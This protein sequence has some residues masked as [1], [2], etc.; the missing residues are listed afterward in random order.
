MNLEGVICCL[1]DSVSSS[2]IGY[3][4]CRNDYEDHRGK[5]G[6]QEKKMLLV[7]VQLFATSWT[8]T[9]QA[10]LS[11]TISQSLLKLV[12]IQSVIPSNHL[13]L[14][15][16]LLLL[17]STFPRIRVFSNESALHIRWRPPP[18]HPLCRAPDD[19]VAVAVISASLSWRP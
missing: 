2:L 9:C 7:P 12:S 17:P 14:C 5:C 1:R 11:F 4:P 8:A 16:P 10:S 18:D 19:T 13:I 6:L 3:P 15:H